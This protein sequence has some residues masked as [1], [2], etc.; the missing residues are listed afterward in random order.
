MRTCISCGTSILDR[1]KLAKRCIPCAK[2]AEKNRRASSSKTEK[3]KEKNKVRSRQRYY[4]QLEKE[5]ERSRLFHAS[6]KEKTAATSMAWRK[7]NAEKVIS[8]RKKYT[9]KAGTALVAKLLGF[10]RDEC[11]SDL[12]EIKREQLLL[13]RA[14]RELNKTLKEQNG[15]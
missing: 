3:E 11:P 10:K 1:S 9:E 14:L 15:N 5:R 4:S 6:N 12:V 2:E 8:N 7:S 13:K